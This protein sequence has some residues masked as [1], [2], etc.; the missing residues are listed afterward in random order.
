MYGCMVN[1]R[2]RINRSMI[3]N[4]SVLFKAVLEGNFLFLGEIHLEIFLMLLGVPFCEL[5]PAGRRFSN[6]N[7][8]SARRC[9]SLA[10]I[11]IGVIP[12]V[13]QIASSDVGWQAQHVRGA[14][15]RYTSSIFLLFVLFSSASILTGAAFVRIEQTI[16]EI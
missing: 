5:S 13:M 6:G 3:D 15:R 8:R 9:H 10:R 16:F 4:L 11:S 12:A 1:R 2:A 7:I 14:L